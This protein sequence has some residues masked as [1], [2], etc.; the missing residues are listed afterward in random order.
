MTALRLTLFGPFEA[1]LA[2]RPLAKFR[3][4]KV[5]ALLVYLAANGGGS[6]GN[7]ESLM[8]LLWPGMP[9]QSA[10]QNLRQ[11]TYFLRK[12]VNDGP[13]DFLLSDN[14]SVSINPEFD[15]QVDVQNF[16]R[17]LRQVRNHEHLDLLNC[18]D[19]RKWLQEAIQLYRGDFLPDF[20][21]PD[22]S[23]FEDWAQ[24]RRELYRRHMLD[25]LDNLAEIYLLGGENRE[26]Q[27]IAQRHLNID[28]LDERGHMHLMEALARNGQRNEALT[29][30]QRL[31]EMIQEELSLEPSERMIA[32]RDR[33]VAGE[34]DAAPVKEKGVRGYELRE[35]IAEGAFGV[36]YRAYQ[37]AVGRDVAIKSILPHYAN[38]PEFI[39]RFEAEAHLVARLEH[40]HVVPLYDY[41]READGAF[42]VMRWFSGNLQ[43][44]LIHGPWSLAAT[45][46]L[47]DQIS[48]A[49]STAHDRDIIHRDIKPAN[50]LLDEAGNAYLGDFGIA[51]DLAILNQQ[52]VAGALIGTPKYLSPEQ[53]LSEPVSPASDIYCLGLVLYE[54]LAGQHPFADTTIQGLM[55]KQLHEP[56]PSLSAQRSDMPVALDKVLLKATDKDPARRFSSVL[57]FAS[58]FRDVVG[59]TTAVQSPQKQSVSDTT[60]FE[61]GEQSLAE[62][63][64]AGREKELEKLEKTAEK[65]LNGKGRILFVIGEAGMG[66]TRLLQ[67]FAQRLA[68]RQPDLLTA[69]GTCTIGNDPYLPFRQVLAALVGGLESQWMA[70]ILTQTQ[71]ARLRK[72]APQVLEMLAEKGS[73]LLG[74]L[75]PVDYLRDRISTMLPN[76]TPLR[77]RL[78]ALMTQNS[79]EKQQ[80]SPHHFFDQYVNVL[81]SLTKKQPL[82]LILDDLQWID[83]ASA[84]LLFHLGRMLPAGRLLLLGAYRSDEV[85]ARV[86]HP[87]QK[88]L[89][90]LQLSYGNIYLNLDK[91][92]D[93]E[94]QHF[95]DTYLDSQPNKL[96]DNFRYTLCDHTEGNPLMTIETLRN[97]QAL[98]YLVQDDEGRWVVGKEL[99]WDNLPSRIEGVIR[100]RTGR[101]DHSLKELLSAASVEGELFTVQVLARLLNRSERELIRQLDRELDKKHR[102]V[103]EVGVQ[104]GA[105]YRLYQYRFRHSVIQQYLYQALSEI[106]REI[107][108]LEI[109][110]ALEGFYKP[111]DIA[112]KLAWHFS[113]GQ[114]S[115]KALKYLLLAGDQ[116]RDKYAP[117]EALSHY[118]MALDL[119]QGQGRNRIAAQT[120]MKVGLVHHTNFDF[121]KARKAFD[122]SF[123]L[124]QRI[125]KD[126]PSGG[127][128]KPKEELRLDW[129]RPVTLDPALAADTFT[130]S[131]IHQLFCGL[132]ELTP[133]LAIVPAVAD[134]WEIGDGGRKYTFH[135]GPDWH[136]HDGRPVIAADFIYAWQRILS[137]ETNSPHAN[138]LYPIRGA[139][140]FHSGKEKDPDTLG[141]SS[142]DDLI[143]VVELD[144]PVSTFLHLLASWPTFPVPSHTIEAYG[145]DW[146]KP[147]KLVGNGPFQLGLDTDDESL[148]LTSNPQYAGKRTGNIGYISIG[149]VDR[150]D[151]SWPLR[152]SNYTNGLVD[153][154]YLHGAPLEVLKQIQAE[155]ASE[156]IA[157]PHFG[158]GY[159]IFD[160]TRPPF[161]DRRV[162]KAMVMVISRQTLANVILAGY[163]YPADGGFIPP[164]MPGHTTDIG[165]PYD[166]DE[167]NRLL[168]EAGYPGGVGCPPIRVFHMRPA[169]EV[170]YLKAQWGIILGLDLEWESTDWQTLMARLNDK[171]PHI[172]ISNATASYPDPVSLLRWQFFAKQMGVLNSPGLTAQLEDALSMTDQ[173]ARIAFFS[174]ADR[175]LMEQAAVVP[176]TYLRNHFLISSKIKN[177][178]VSPLCW[179]FWS[180]VVMEEASNKIG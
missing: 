159:M 71:A 78:E 7:R 97:L 31:E 138:I 74:P 136:W 63:P 9:Q 35:K 176:L 68:A 149:L 153:E 90:E 100:E 14:E 112:P 167:A 148:I 114:M 144:R 117:V 20:Y 163:E 11:T 179:W 168:A 131:L 13:V 121:E 81:V 41:W 76:N 158:V 52:T 65:T 40:P 56:I 102:L 128:Q 12:A 49:L 45:Q 96:N 137:K 22:S 36:V 174:T 150:W 15:W 111:E 124:W 88:V 127:F 10:Q 109:G 62:M 24:S 107:L 87:L 145:E 108:H 53:I 27:T 33:I 161:D 86:S 79:A 157:T 28:D 54:I 152:L 139:Q 146:T 34:L 178:P 21:L 50:I 91:I 51:K 69:F 39:R 151:E 57:E 118:E 23:D 115:D 16:T 58:A 37:P 130:G 175:L 46:R 8:T 129:L 93:T 140:T 165:L 6:A 172:V 119:A 104:Q 55:Y 43:E 84:K 177:F 110:E 38:Q 135:L 29:H 64:F 66:K 154:L 142:P 4:N 60:L 85:A 80:D 44:S 113:H 5:K 48:A 75:L 132:V 141:L 105:G 26:A 32:L 166:P 122:A 72:A 106:E 67:V 82:L 156:Y 98:G 126:L 95:V 19:C 101:L 61:Q 171:R 164:G 180:D 17:L 155:H 59:A 3:T 123:T 92:P 47:V 25:A 103:S 160:M 83:A 89:D 18:P 162:R 169:H 99:V 125:G 170:N 120:Y 42:L 173:T 116:A 30:Y 133:Q 70:G 77:E 2:G 134:R 73:D 143:L 147:G 1:T 94:R